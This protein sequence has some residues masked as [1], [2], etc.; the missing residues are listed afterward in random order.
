MNEKTLRTKY[1]NREICGPTE[2]LTD[3]DVAEKLF[4]GATRELVCGLI[5]M[6]TKLELIIMGKVQGNNCK[7]EF[8]YA[9]SIISLCRFAVRTAIGT[10][11]TRND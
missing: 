3:A 10:R 8:Y 9:G 4:T 1:S 2:V 11:C 5:A 6:E 7:S